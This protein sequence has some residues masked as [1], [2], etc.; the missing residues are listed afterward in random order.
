MKECVKF[1]YVYERYGT[2]VPENILLNDIWVDIGNAEREGVFDHHQYGGLKSAF[3][4]VLMYPEGLKGIRTYLDSYQG[5][6][7]EVVLHMHVYPDLDCIMSA[8]MVQ[9]LIRTGKSH[10]NEIFSAH[11]IEK[12]QEYVNEIDAGKRKVVSDLTLYAYLCRIGL[13]ERD[14]WK[15]SQQILNEGLILVDLAVQVLEKA[16]RDIDLFTE[17]L[18]SYMDITK[19]NGYDTARRDLELSKEHYREDKEANRVVLKSINLWNKEEACIKP[20]KAAIWKELPSGEDGYVFAR[21]L[22]DCILT[23]YP[24]DIRQEDDTSMSRVTR[25]VISLNPNM[26]ESESYTLLPVAEMLEQCEQL[27][28]NILFEKTGNYRRDHSHSRE[29]RGRFSEV[30]FSSTND[31]WYISEKED[32]IDSPRIKSLL[33][34]EHLLNIIEN[35][36]AMAKS[37]VM[38]RFYKENESIQTEQVAG[39]TEVSFGELY[40]LAQKQVC[41]F[42]NREQS[43]YLLTIVKIDSSMLKYSNAILKTC[44]LNMVGKNGSRMSDDNL[45]YLDYRTCLYTDQVVTVLAM[46]DTESSVAQRLVADQVL[47]SRICADL[48]HILEHRQELRS[49]GVSLSEKIRTIGETDGEIEMFNRRLVHLNTRIQI[50]DLILDPVEQEV[51]SFIK[52]N[53]GIVPLKE[54]VIT[55]AEL[56]IKNAEQKRDRDMEAARNE[57][58]KR[59]KQAEKAERRRDKQLQAI[60]GWFTLLGIA[61][62]FNDGF[63]FIS[64]MDAGTSWS[65][66]SPGGRYVGYIFLTVIVVIFLAA[67]VYTLK[68][69]ISAW[70]DKD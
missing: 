59:E 28:E 55:S 21:D 67:L 51:Y 10:L 26:K 27:E 52:A 11:T 32:I 49:I 43:E 7:P 8:Y 36:S 40:Q 25:A 41:E 42:Q 31:P 38:I 35:D 3:E 69:T 64:K 70:K 57:R 56:L 30:P 22:D 53:L 48:K 13:G 47:N 62:A 60:M 24:Y 6:E 20:V 66:L 2:I 58:E 15:R 19:L 1:R 61:S 39:Y 50:D 4:C 37:A 23:V 12:L 63:D 18:E 45:L 29:K 17:P 34:Y 5:T 65:Q 14:V 9:K 16:E 68:T 44:C 33:S 46:A 54:S